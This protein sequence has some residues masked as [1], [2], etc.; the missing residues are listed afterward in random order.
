MYKVYRNLW[1]KLVNFKNLWTAFKKATRGNRS[2]GSVAAFEFDLENNLYEL[3]EKLSK[4]T[5]QPGGYD[6]FYIHDPKK[7][8]I[9]AAPF[10]D[11]V[12]HHAVVNIVGSIYERKFIYDSYANRVGKGTHRALDLCTQ[13]LRKFKYVLPMDIQEYF[14]I[15][16]NLL[17]I[18]NIK[19]LLGFEVAEL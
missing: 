8:L 5:F 2:N 11:R 16:C 17:Q 3:Q 19:L 10:R 1:P 7:R 6:S 15:G 9:S 13:Y 14:P 18:K 4:R 12:V